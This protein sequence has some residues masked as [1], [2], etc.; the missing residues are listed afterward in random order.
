MQPM[1]FAAD[2]L[3]ELRLLAVASVSTGKNVA[4]VRQETFN[5]ERQ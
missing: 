4:N 3:I 1:H 2:L 5:W